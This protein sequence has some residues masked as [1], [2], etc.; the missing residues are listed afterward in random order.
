MAT[1][2]LANVLQKGAKAD[3]VSSCISNM[4]PADA[5]KWMGQ[6]AKYVALATGDVL[7][8]PYGTITWIVGT[9]PTPS[10][11]AWF[12]VL[13][14]KL[15]L[16]MEPKVREEVTRCTDDFLKGVETVAPWDRLGPVVTRFMGVA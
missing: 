9:S 7:F 4:T 15:F 10:S 5:K 16:S 3:T 13:S 11:T 6:N 1:L 14:E 12:P 8:I 2:S